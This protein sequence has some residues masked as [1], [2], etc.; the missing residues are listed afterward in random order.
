MERGGRLTVRVAARPDGMA[1]IEIGDTGSGIAQ[2]H[3]SKLFDPFFSTKA[4]GTGLGLALVQQIAV[5]HGGRVDVESGGTDVGTN[6]GT[7]FRLL[8]PM[9]REPLP[10]AG[11]GAMGEA[12]P[13]AAPSAASFPSPSAG[14]AGNATPTAVGSVPA[15]ATADLRV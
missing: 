13:K 6:A 8:L 5:E 10:L 7:T 3:L 1:E 14:V 2:E 9:L 15:A 12:T 11:S 4:K